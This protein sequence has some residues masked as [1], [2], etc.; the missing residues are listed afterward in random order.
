MPRRLEATVVSAIVASLRA[1]GAWLFKTHGDASQVKGIPDLVVC[2]RG[3]FI[4]LEVKR[5]EKED[6]EDL[7]AYTLVEIERAGGLVGVVD[8]VEDVIALLEK[9]SMCAPANPMYVHKIVP[10]RVVKAVEHIK[11]ARTI[12]TVSQAYT[13]M[14]ELG[15]GELAQVENQAPYNSDVGTLRLMGLSDLQIIAVGA[16]MLCAAECAGQMV[17]NEDYHPTAQEQ[18]PITAP[19]QAY[20]VPQDW[21]F[22]R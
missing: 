3:R 21:A 19:P 17:E 9:D 2:Y 20:E 7:Q 6:A 11:I 16:A 1:R 8:S 15:L 14:V 10:E 22:G 12:L 5:D 13:V 4:G 18:E